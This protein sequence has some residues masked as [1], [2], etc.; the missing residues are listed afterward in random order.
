MLDNKIY[1]NSQD[2]LYRSPFGSCPIGQEVTL[3]ISIDKGVVIQEVLLAMH[4]EGRE[5]EL[6][7]MT[8]YSEAADTKI[9]EVKV[10]LPHEPCLIWYYFSIKANNQLLFYGNNGKGLGGEGAIYEREPLLYQITVYHYREKQP[11]WFMDAIMYQIFPDRFYVDDLQPKVHKKNSF[12]YSS[13]YD[14]PRYIRDETGRISKWDFFGGNLMG[15]IKKL[16][17]LQDLGITVIYLNPIFLSPSNHRYDTSDYKRIDDSL[18]DEEIFQMLCTKAKERGIEIILDGV[19]SHTGSD[20]IYFNKEGNFQELGAYQSSASI[21]YKWYSFEEYPNKY[22]CWW[23]YDNMPNVVELEESFQN[24]IIWDEDSVIKRWGKIGIKGWRLDVADELPSDFIKAFK[25]GIREIDQDSILIGELWDDA[26]NKITYGERREYFLGDELDSVMNYPLRKILHDFLLERATG[27]ELNNV[28]MS[29][30]ENYPPYNF[31]NNMNLTGSHDVARSMTILGEAP[32]DLTIDEK[33]TY[34]LPPNQRQIAVKRVK[35]LALFQM[36]LP[37]VPS[38]YYGDEVGLEGFDDPLNRK[39]F[40]WGREDREIFHW[41][42]EM[43]KLRQENSVFKRGK[44]I[45]LVTEDRVY[46]Y[47]RT[48]YEDRDVFGNEMK[49]RTALVLINSHKEK[50]IDIRIDLS[51]WFNLKVQDTLS[52]NKV[53]LM[54]GIL[55]ISLNSLEG[56]VFFQG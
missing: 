11:N 49:G 4:I 18:G 19:F 52:K 34:S 45:P 14:P 21:Y 46:G 29:L 38:I 50:A 10:K 9:F 37:G 22:N 42:R 26:S 48:F 30:F 53:E 31:Y 39:T 33:S 8:L 5:E 51:K 41:Y 1:H 2:I 15:I 28:I 35:L 55:S 40:P 56:R 13:W 3:R 25:K 20:S 24:Y 23:G 54:D 36:T 47:L 17:Y 7:T 6:Y 44:W 32:D 27:H 16:G 12:T 43:I